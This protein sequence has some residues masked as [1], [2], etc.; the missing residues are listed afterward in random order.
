MKILVNISIG[1][2]GAVMVLTCMAADEVGE[3]TYSRG[4]LTGQVDGEQPRLIGK[5]VALRNGETLNTG[6][7]GFAVIELDD[8]TRMT[9]RPSTTFKIENV[10]TDE[11]EESALLS[12]IR[13]GLRAITGF[14]SKASPDAFQ[15]G[16]SVATIGIRGTEFD[17]RL[18]AGGEC[19]QEEDASGQEARRESRVVGRIA[20]L[21]GMASA[22]EDGQGSR[23]LNTGAAVY[24]RD[25]IETGIKSFVVIAFNDETRATLAPQS[26]FRIEEH[27]YAPQQP[28]ENNSFFSFLRGGLRV[29]TGLIGRL[30]QKAFRVATPTATIGIRG[31]GFDLVC[32]GSCSSDSAALDP[33]G[34]SLLGR[35]L[36]L[37]VKPAYALG[38]G[39]GMYA[40]VWRGTIE[41]Q[42]Q[43]DTVLLDNGRTAYL[44]NRVS[45]PQIIG[46][47]PPGLR[48]MGGAPRPDRVPIPD[49][50][51]IEIDASVIEP[52]L[53]VNVRKGDVA[54]AGLDG[55]VVNIGAGEA[56]LAN[57]LRAVRLSFVPAFQK[58]DAMPDPARMTV[59]SPKMLDLFG[60]RGAERQTME[61]TVQ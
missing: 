30:N 32:E 25:Q 45:V 59:Q 1:A 57:D 61:C 56:L 13:G 27:E 24:E 15:I 39:N 51:F 14:I 6:S 50:A 34:G 37:L 21:R 38:D 5:G 29:V 20:L 9:L 49:D 31:T 43:N 23:A 19:Q 52:G 2:L 16:T 40:K 8:G 54:V 22:T 41:L 10:D 28:D 11:G 12:L 36:N 26:A 3:V 33:A 44:R 60:P 55:K 18:C 35:F 48:I 17:A 42:L 4:V 7:R 53:Y 58:F 46:D 47:I